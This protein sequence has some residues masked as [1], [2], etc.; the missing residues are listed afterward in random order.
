MPDPA[1]AN[2]ARANIHQARAAVKLCPCDLCIDRLL[3]VALTDQR[4]RLEAELRGVAKSYQRLADAAREREEWRTA[5]LAEV[6][7]DQCEVCAGAIRAGG[8]G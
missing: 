6:R 7:V 1:P 8:E 3:K 4:A 2:Q 5:E